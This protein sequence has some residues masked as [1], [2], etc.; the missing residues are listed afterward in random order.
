MNEEE[1]NIMLIATPKEIIGKMKYEN[2]KPVEIGVLTEE[3]Q[4]VFDEF[5]E[6]FERELKESFVDETA[7]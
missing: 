7:E 3:E 1:R 2:G 4:Q 5:C 6:D